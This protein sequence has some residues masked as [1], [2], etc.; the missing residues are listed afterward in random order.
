MKRAYVSDEQDILKCQGYSTTAYICFCRNADVG[1]ANILAY[2]VE[3]L[4]NDITN[5]ILF[6]VVAGQFLTGSAFI[7]SCNCTQRD[8]SCGF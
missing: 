3:V 1:N 8:N 6:S 7:C 4:Y 2:L 5:G